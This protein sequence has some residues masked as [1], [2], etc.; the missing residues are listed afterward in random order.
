MNQSLKLTA[1][2][3][4][5]LLATV[6][7]AC[8]APTRPNA[9]DTYKTIVLAEVVGLYLTDYTRERLE[10]MKDG[11]PYTSPSDASP[12]YDVDLIVFENLKG[13]AEQTMSLHV[14]AGCGTQKPDLNQ[15]GIFYINADGSAHVVL[16]H[17]LDY[18]ERLEKLGSRFTGLCVTTQE[19]FTPHPCWKPMQ[20]QL[21]CMILIKDMAYSRR[22]SCPAGVSELYE[23]MKEQIV[24]PYGWG[25]PPLRD[26]Q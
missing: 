8:P 7:W 26:P 23:R 5:L 24:A 16:Q 12:G 17:F 21:D 6:S 9:D 3:F 11:R 22:S 14:T 20:S 10:Q 18:R 2:T 25:W 15:F 13:S 19:R 1:M 4:G